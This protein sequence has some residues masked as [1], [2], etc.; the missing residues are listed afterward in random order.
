MVE[1]HEKQK[2]L[3]GLKFTGKDEKK[4]KKAK[5]EKKDKKKDKKSKK[6]KKKTKK[7][8]KAKSSSSSSS[9]D[10]S[11]HQ[12]DKASAVAASAKKSQLK[13]KQGGLSQ[14]NRSVSPVRAPGEKDVPKEE[15]VPVDPKAQQ[16]MDF[17]SSF[18]TVESEK[19]E[20]PRGYASKGLNNVADEVV[21]KKELNPFLK[22]SESTT[23]DVES[24]SLIPKHLCV[25]DRG[26]AWRRRAEKRAREEKPVEEPKKTE[27]DPKHI[28]WGGKAAKQTSNIAGGKR[29][30]RVR[31][32]ER[33]RGGGGDGGEDSD[34]EVGIPGGATEFAHRGGTEEKSDAEDDFGD[35]AED[36][37]GRSKVDSVS[38]GRNQIKRGLAA[39]S[40]SVRSEDP[41][42]VM[43]RMR[44]KYGGG[45]A[46]AP[47]PA[48]TKGSDAVSE[49]DPMVIKESADELAAQAMNA[50]LAG[51]MAKYAELNEKVAKLQAQKAA[52]AVAEAPKMESEKEAAPAQD[53]NVTR[54]L[55]EVDGL[56]RSRKLVESVQTN[57]VNLGNKKGQKKLKNTVNM[58]RGDK[59]GQAKGYYEDDNISL[60]ELIKRERIEGVQDYESNYANYILKKGVKF[61]DLDEDEDAAYAL[62][63]YESA[64]RKMDAKKL[65]E[66]QR[67]FQINEQHRVQKNLENCTFCMDS[68]K[69]GR[70][71]AVVSISNCAYLC[72]DSQKNCLLE[73]QFF[74]APIEHVP[75][76]LGIDETIQAEIRNYQKCLI[77][78]FESLK[79]PQAP[80]FVES[81]IKEVSKEKALLGGGG[82]AV[83]QVL[84]VALNRLDEARTFFR[85]ALNDS[86]TEW[87][88][89]KKV[90]DTDGK[91]GVHGVIPKGFTYIHIDFALT[92]G[93]AHQVED[94]SQW[95]KDFALQVIA[96]MNKVT[97]LDRAYHSK[98]EYW[99]S[100]ALL[101]QRFRPHDWAQA[102]ESETKPRGDRNGPSLAA[103]AGKVKD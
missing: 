46:E 86:E 97:I 68:Q 5:K 52:A 55:E 82:H 102:F 7:D 14:K 99:D 80:I 67:R 90:L 98:T 81:N 49:S 88:Q 66:K 34:G 17:F 100:V 101:K 59:K 2:M 22:G 9:S 41:E 28:K 94:T 26:A 73:N 53:T 89:H 77:R 37:T 39:L 61:K 58:D 54:V 4:D 70:K 75:C 76:M 15:T 23:R 50:M 8:K 13:F 25:G 33:S 43:R 62:E 64:D 16:E 38:D 42:D 51:D 74:I 24:G 78:F 92:G 87:A 83:I 30:W 35:N 48:H 36:N 96:G 10:D 3:A 31:A 93:F 44:S 29:N 95:P 85:K 1:E 40:Q 32:A 60:E 72:V 18:G 84:P 57:S 11:A 20:T 45:P 6:E 12:P 21:H 65:A 69:F 103:L 19:K 71:D 27:D 79:P 47:S 56:G 63:R 91:R